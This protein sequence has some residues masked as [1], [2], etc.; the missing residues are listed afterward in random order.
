MATTATDKRQVIPLTDRAI[1]NLKP[2]TKP[3][4][5]FDGQGLYLEVSPKGKKVFR[6]KAKL[7]DGKPILMTLG[8]YPAVTLAEARQKRQELRKQI[9]KG[10]DP[11]RVAKEKE[12]AERLRT[13]STL[14]N[15]TAEWLRARTGKVVPATLEN[16]GRLFKLHIFPVLGLI[17]VADITARDVLN[18]LLSIEKK[19][20][21]LARHVK[22]NLARVF[23]YAISLGMTDRNPASE[24]IT[25][26]ILKRH[27]TTHQK[28]IRLEELPSLLKALE[29]DTAGLQVKSAIRLLMMLFMR[30]GELINAEWSHI[31]LKAGLWKI[32]ADNTKKRREQ[33]YPLPRQA[34]AVLTELHRLTGRCRYVFSTWARG[35]DAPLGVTTLM[36]PIIRCGYFGKMTVHGFRALATSWLD[37]Q[38]YSRQAIERQLSHLEK[39]QTNQAYHRA[40][41]M[42]ERREM[43]QAWADYLDSIKEQEIPQAGDKAA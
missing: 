25:R 7:A 8:E 24:L 32:P 17:P 42:E 10:L 1:R 35:K 30:R 13:E 16:T 14:E 38:G 43:L 19:S 3:V 21:N 34:I 20:A 4:T 31:D 5:S 15:V 23:S 39:G 18:L 22:S 37:E 33:V 29:N 9:A 27:V 41:Y 28:T 12:L 2:S 6:F 26:D 11:R 40:D 36:Q